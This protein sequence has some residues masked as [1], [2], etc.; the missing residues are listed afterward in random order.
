MEKINVAKELGKN[1]NHKIDSGNI[2]DK[3]N[4]IM[5]FVKLTFHNIETGKDEVIH[6]LNVFCHA[7]KSGIARRIA[8]QE[9]NYGRVTYCAVGTGTN[10]PSASDT[11][12]QTELFRKTISVT[13]YNSNV[14]TFTTFYDT[15]EANGTLKELG[16]F[17]DLADETSN[18]G[19]LYAHTSIDKT[20]TSSDTLTIEWSLVI[21]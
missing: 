20:K 5:G 18:S 13:A 12:L 15:A 16:L 1:Y 9:S 6:I 14:A 21:N 10:V 4:G 8:N 2:Y 7:G 11:T 3:T 19:T 17:G